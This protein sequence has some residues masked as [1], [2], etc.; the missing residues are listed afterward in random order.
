M[1]EICHHSSLTLLDVSRA[2][3]CVLGMLADAHVRHY[4]GSRAVTWATPPRLKWS[5]D[6]LH[7]GLPDVVAK[8][9]YHPSLLLLLRCAARKA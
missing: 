2:Y 9:H 4:T 3:E 1:R 7:G 5:W 6:E 8:E